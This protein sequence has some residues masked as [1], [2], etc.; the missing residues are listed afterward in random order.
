MRDIAT[1]EANMCDA[2]DM[3]GIF[4]SWL[5]LLEKTKEKIIKVG[6]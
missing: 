4:S 2:L 6:S 5:A 3:N 1:Y